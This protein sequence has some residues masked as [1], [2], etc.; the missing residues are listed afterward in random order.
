[1]ELFGIMFGCCLVMLCLAFITGDSED[2]IYALL[3]IGFVCYLYLWNWISDY[4]TEK[5]IF[6]GDVEGSDSKYTAGTIVFFIF[7]G[8]I[9]MAMGLYLV[10]KNA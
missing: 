6:A 4:L 2:F 7:F 3:G 1:M 5:E 10:F 8:L 9:P